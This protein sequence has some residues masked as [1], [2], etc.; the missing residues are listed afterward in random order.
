MPVHHVANGGMVLAYEPTPEERVVL[1]II[2]TPDGTKTL[3][4]T[5]LRRYDEALAFA[6][7]I[8]AWQ[9]HAVTVLP[10]TVQEHFE[11]NHP[12]LWDR[13]TPDERRRAL[14]VCN[15]MQL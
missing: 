6:R 13:A 4:A 8:A 10:V 3:W 14:D 15:A 11:M 2:G 7:Q 9:H 5:P 1:L 12:K